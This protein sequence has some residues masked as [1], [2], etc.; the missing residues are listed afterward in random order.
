MKR[1]KKIIQIVFAVSTF[2]GVIAFIAERFEKSNMH[3]PYGIY[4]HYLKRP[5]DAF[6]ATGALIIFSPVLVMTALLVRINL[7]S[8][9]LF[10]QER[11]GKNEKV[12]KLLKFRSMSDERDSNGRLLPDEVRMTKFGKILR[13]SSLDELIS[14][15]NIVK[16]DMAVVGPRP[17]LVRYI[18]RYS[19][20]QHR[21]HEVRSG[22]TGLAQVHGR[23]A[24]T[25][26]DKFNW[27]IQYVDRITFTGDA[28]IILNTL[29][30]VLKREGIN[31]AASVTMPEFLGS[32][33]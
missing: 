31:N 22:L 15:V 5:F 21:R 30:A 32:S 2:V 24:T 13:A 10:V 27:D 19:A 23:N 12:F 9:V 17:L 20:E 33:R 28:K 4:E 6:L 25:W 11:P 1:M 18:P 8:P 7:G 29:K 26:D 16:G 3:K 14:L